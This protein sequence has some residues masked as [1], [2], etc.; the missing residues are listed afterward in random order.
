MVA[1]VCFRLGV[2]DGLIN[3]FINSINSGDITSGRLNQFT[4]LFTS[5]NFKLYFFKT[6]D[7]SVYSNVR[8]LQTALEFPVLRWAFVFGIFMSII[9]FMSIFVFP[10]LLLIKRKHYEVLISFILISAPVNGYSG[11]SDV[12]NKAMYFYIVVFLIISY[13]NIIMF[14]KNN[15]VNKSLHQYT[16]VNYC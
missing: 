5:G 1:Y 10:M 9:L 2:F 13:S 7:L 3:R 16:S 11:I 8:A 15:N 4:R 14:E 6:Q 12:G